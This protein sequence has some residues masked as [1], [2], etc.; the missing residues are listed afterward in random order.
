ML[1]LLQLHLPTHSHTQV[2]VG[3]AG[4]CVCVCEYVAQLFVKALNFRYQQMRKSS[5]PKKSA[6][7][8]HSCRSVCGA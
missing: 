5:Q 3:Y 6:K 7:T 2:C 4:V 8:F 1:Y